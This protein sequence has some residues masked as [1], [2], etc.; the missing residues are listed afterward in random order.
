MNTFTK[1]FGCQNCK[2]EYNCIWI[3]KNGQIKI[4]TQI[5]RPTWIHIQIY[6]YKYEYLPQTS[7]A[8]LVRSS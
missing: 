8:G 7:F 1:V 2:Y 5:F 6:K 3:D 4:Q